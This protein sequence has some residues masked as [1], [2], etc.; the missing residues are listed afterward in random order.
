MDMTYPNGTATL[1]AI[2]D[3]TTSLYL[4][5]GGGII[6]AGGHENVAHDNR[7]LLVVAEANLASFSTG[8]ADSLPAVNRVLITALTYSGPRRVEALEDDL[9]H[10]RHPA[11]P[12]FHAAHQ[13]IGALRTVDRPGASPQPPGE[14]TPLMAAAHRG[15]P[16]TAAEL[17][18]RG[19]PLEARDDSGYT[20]LMYGANAGQDEVVRLLLN[21][22]ADPNATDA[23]N[24]TSLMFA[25]QHDHLGVVHQLIAAGADVNA[26][27]DHGLTALGFAQQNGH[28]RTA[29]ALLTSGAS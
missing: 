20:A 29:A 24:N 8:L 14:A 10:S 6:G 16:V 22:G 15:D 13:V 27:G 23:H 11:A 2:A 21:C 28:Q 12:V 17:V 18:N 9:G 25:A 3:G 7:H 26:R 4:G 19:A 1:V 5:S